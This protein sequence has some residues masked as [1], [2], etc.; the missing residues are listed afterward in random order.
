MSCVQVPAKLQQVHQDTGRVWCLFGDSAFGL[1]LYMQRMLRGAAARTA[2]G[3]RFN[4][5]MASVRVSIENAFA[6]VL[7]RWRFVG[8]KRLQVLG[9]MPVAKHVAVAVMFHNMYN[10]LYGSQAV[11]MFGP[12]L[13]AGLTLE[14]YVDKIR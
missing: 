3:K 9:T 10:I 2:A 14:R 6:E 11:C 7:N 5:Q 4:A 12:A 8:V 13:R 1:S